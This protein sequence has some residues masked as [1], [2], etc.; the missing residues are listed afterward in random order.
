[1]VPAI[2]KGRVLPKMTAHACKRLTSKN[3]RDYL[4]YLEQDPEC[5]PGVM[6][7]VQAQ[8]TAGAQGAFGNA[9][10]RRASPSASERKRNCT[11]FGDRADFE[12]TQ[13]FSSNGQTAYND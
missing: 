1:M 10:T 7:H 12:K 3:L 8:I 6:K 4:H 9:A 11:L 5:N 13:C 2:E